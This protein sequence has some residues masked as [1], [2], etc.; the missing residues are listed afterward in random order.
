M[1][2]APGSDRASIG[3]AFLLTR[4]GAAV[5][6]SISP[7][8]L[9]IDLDGQKQSALTDVLLV[10]YERAAVSPIGRGENSG[11]MLKEYNIV[12]SLRTVGQWDGREQQYRI[13]RGALPFDA[14]DVAVIIQSQSQ[15][16]IIG[17]ATLS[18]R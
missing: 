7:S 9:L 1:G 14:T 11:R 4:S 17:A 15:A 6:L 2:A 13:P 18:L 8:E 5:R 12:R 16:P 3:R 10:S